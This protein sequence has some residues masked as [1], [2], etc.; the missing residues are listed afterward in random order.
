MSKTMTQVLEL[1]VRD[2]HCKRTD[3]RNQD[4]YS[5]EYCHSNTTILNRPNIILSYEFHNIFR[6]KCMAAL[7]NSMN[8]KDEFTRKR[9]C[10]QNYFIPETK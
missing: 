10:I 7:I 2:V 5:S 9:N 8:K 6:A 3:P 4:S 1:G